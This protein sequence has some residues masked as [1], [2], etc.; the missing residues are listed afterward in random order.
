MTYVHFRYDHSTFFPLFYEIRVLFWITEQYVV[1]FVLLRVFFN[2]FIFFTG[3]HLVVGKAQL[4][5]IALRFTVF[6]SSVPVNQDSV[7]VSQQ[8]HFQRILGLK[9]HWF[10]YLH[11]L[12][13]F[14]HMSK[15]QAWMSLTQTSHTTQLYAKSRGE[16]NA[17]NAITCYIITA[18]Q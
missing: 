8:E 17:C 12:F 4:L 1:S 10:D 15:C 11:I 3:R 18:P 7:T 16:K 9:H 6:Y 2:N 5:L 14:C 13:S